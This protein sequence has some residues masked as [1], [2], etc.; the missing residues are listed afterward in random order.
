MIDWAILSEIDVSETMKAQRTMFK[1]IWSII[2]VI[3]L[4]LIPFALFAG[5]KVG[6]G[7]SMPIHQLLATIQE[8]ARNATTAADK[9]K[10][11]DNKC[12]KSTQSAHKLE[13]DMSILMKKWNMLRILFQ[14]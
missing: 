14:N 12:S 6:K 1:R 10:V 2:F 13:N 3:I 9:V 11:T 5:F 4:I 8:V 7:I